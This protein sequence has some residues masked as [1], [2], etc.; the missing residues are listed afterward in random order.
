M[1]SIDPVGTIAPGFDAHEFEPRTV[2]VPEREN[3]FAE[4]LFGFC[5]PPERAAPVVQNRDRRSVRRRTY[6][7]GPRAALLNSL[8]RKKRD[9]GSRRTCLIPVV[10][11][12]GS[13]IIEIH[14]ALD[15]SQPKA[16]RIEVDVALRGPGYRRDVVNS[17]RIR[18]VSPCLLCVRLLALRR[19]RTVLP[20]V[21]PGVSRARLAPIQPELP[22]PDL[23]WRKHR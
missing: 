12:P 1:E 18:H 17:C 4:S 15:Q 6:F 20:G 13:R 3:E 2:R 19:N 9:Q 11:V 16:T 21:R 8:P 22:A 5:L 23:T 7:A 14:G 10:Q